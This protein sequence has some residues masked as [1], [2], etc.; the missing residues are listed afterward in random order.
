MNITVH[1]G[2][3]QVGG[4]IIEISTKTTRILLDMGRSFSTDKA[5]RKMPKIEGLSS[6]PSIDAVFITH[7]HEDHV[8]MVNRVHRTIP[9][10]MGEKAYNILKASDTYKFKRLFKVAGFLMHRKSIQIG[11][12]KVTPYSC[13]HAAYDSY[14]LY[15][16]ADGES[17][18]YTGDFRGH[19]RAGINFISELPKNP[20]TLIC[21]GSELHHPDRRAVSELELE[22]KAADIIAKAKG[23]V[24]TVQVPLNVDRTVALYN[25]AH[26]NSRIFIEDAY[27]AQIAKAAGVPIPC[28]DKMKDV[29][30]FLPSFIRLPWY[31]SLKN[32]ISKDIIKSKPFVMCVRPLMHRYIKRLSKKISFEGGVLIYSCRKGLQK[33]WFMKK[34]VD[35]C[36]KLGLEHIHLH[37]GGHADGPTIK[38]LIETVTP[39]NLIPIHTEYPKEFEKLAPNVNI[40]Y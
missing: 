1:R 27:M 13:D 30:A 4:N 33:S 11:D 15:C 16:E 8:G 7:Y 37:A 20:D 35:E 36:E 32:K 39:K 17:V 40:I 2:K 3:E 26:K 9:I 18:L 5:K 19:G 21:E 24:F 34:L 6:R 22:Q 38:Y 12:I 14:M 10:Y 31:T 28:P 25:A 29:Y 23:P